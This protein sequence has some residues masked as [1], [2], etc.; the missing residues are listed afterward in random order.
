MPVAGAGQDAAQQLKRG[1][2][3][4]RMH[5]NRPP[6]RALAGRAHFGKRLAFV[7]PMAGGS[8]GRSAPAR[9][10]ICAGPRSARLHRAARR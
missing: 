5:C 7:Y 10:R 9:G 8:S 3:Q 4:A 6:G 2:Q 1:I